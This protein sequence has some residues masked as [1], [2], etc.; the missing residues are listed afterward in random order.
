MKKKINPV[1]EI[2]MFLL[3]L[4]PVI[5][6]LVFWKSIPEQVPVHWNIN[7]EID[8]YGHKMLIPFLNIG[9]YLLLLIVVFIDPRKENYERF[10]KVYNAIRWVLSIFF[11]A[12]SMVII[13]VSLGYPISM[14]RFLLISLPLLFALLGNYMLN[15]KPN[16]FMGIRTPWT[17]SSETVWRK[18]HRL[19][20][21]MWFWAG[22]GCCALAFFADTR[23]GFVVLVT[24]IA[25]ITL[26][27][28]TY[29]YVLFR[30][31]KQANGKNT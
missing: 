19:A 31:E 8:G 26:I 1:I 25:I 5:L 2:P 4:V 7:G 11:V 12:V 22:T 3:N 18:T 30:K 13:L 17:M 10:R 24:T 27:P 6:T 21:W 23:T 28:V 9:L 14:D 15:I 16:W 20:G 29:S